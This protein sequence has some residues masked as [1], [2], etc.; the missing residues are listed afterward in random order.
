MPK[1]AVAERASDGEKGGKGYRSG[2]DPP[3][4][5]FDIALRAGREQT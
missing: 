5:V 2:G 3:C 4:L 1:I